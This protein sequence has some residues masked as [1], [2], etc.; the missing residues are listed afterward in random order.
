MNSYVDP[1]N[2]T[3]L[4]AERVEL[5]S[6]W[7]DFYVI[8]F[9]VVLVYCFSYCC[10]QEEREGGK[11]GREG[12]KELSGVLQGRAEGLTKRTELD[13]NNQ[14]SLFLSSTHMVHLATFL[15]PVL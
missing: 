7:C 11:E 6:I 13:L 15:L 10:C 14:E 9:V 12:G 5:T 3:L 1:V 2:I 4:K 8:L